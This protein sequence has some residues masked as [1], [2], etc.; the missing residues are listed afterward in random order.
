MTVCRFFNLAPANQPN[1]NP[2]AYMQFV[3]TCKDQELD[4][5]GLVDARAAKMQRL[6]GD[7]PACPLT[8]EVW[9]CAVCV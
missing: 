8:V 6:N 1:S 3:V 4:A 2:P 5:V 7:D 9:P